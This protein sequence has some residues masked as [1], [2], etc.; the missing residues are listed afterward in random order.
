MNGTAARFFRLGVSLSGLVVLGW[1]RTGQA[2][3]LAKHGI[4]LPTDWSHRHLV[5]SRPSSAE[6][7]ARVGE[8]PRYWQELHRREEA[9]RLPASVA[10]ASAGAFAPASVEG[11][12]LK[13]LWS[14]DLGCGAS[15]GGGNY[16]AKF[17]LDITTA[18]CATDYFAF[19]TGQA[20][21]VGPA[22]IVAFN[23]LYSGCGGT[24]PSVYWAYN[25]SG[26]GIGQILMHSRF[27]LHAMSGSRVH[28][29]QHAR[30]VVAGLREIIRQ[31]RRALSQ[32]AGQETARCRESGV[33]SSAPGFCRHISRWR[34]CV[35]GTRFHPSTRKHA[36]D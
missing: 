29:G 2:A 18:N 21:A 8:D 11:K 34:D 31:N 4:P 9:L 28:R 12:K 13:G 10:D 36:S 25:T 24:V 19:S 26:S 6:Q 15:L 27:E 22:S 5:F 20:G 33:D 32:H 23:N 7:L 3:K 30:P 17:S 35:I 16:P 1:V 14:E